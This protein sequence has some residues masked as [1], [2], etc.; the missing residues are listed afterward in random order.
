MSKLD[1][2]MVLHL[3]LWSLYNF[4]TTNLF[5]LT[6]M[7]FILVAMSWGEKPFKASSQW[8]FLWLG[9]CGSFYI[10]FWCFVFSLC[11]CHFVWQHLRFRDLLT[12]IPSLSWFFWLEEYDWNLQWFPLMLV[13][14]FSLFFL[15]SSGFSNKTGYSVLV[16]MISGTTSCF[17]ILKPKQ[18][19][20]GVPLI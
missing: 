6:Q 17:G 20:N 4:F 14:Q 3:R 16:P 7:F 10:R 1:F 12:N 19:I 15:I 18:L 8:K 9:F 5:G 2:P 11:L 13:F